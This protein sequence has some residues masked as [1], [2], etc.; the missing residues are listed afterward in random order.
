MNFTS[1]VTG[2]WN[3]PA[4]WGIAPAGGPS[5]PGYT[6]P[7][8]NDTVSITD[9]AAVIIPA[10][11]GVS[12]GSSG[13]I[14]IETNTYL[15]IYGSLDNGGAITADS[16]ITIYPGGSLTNSGSITGYGFIQN[17][18]KMINN[19]GGVITETLLPN[20]GT[21]NFF[22]NEQNATITNDGTIDISAGFANYGSLTNAGTLQVNS[23]GEVTGTGSITNTGTVDLSGLSLQLIETSTLYG[24]FQTVGGT[25]TQGKGSQI[26]LDVGT[27][28]VVESWS[29]SNT[30]FTIPAG[31]SLLIG[32]GSTLTIKGSQTLTNNGTIA[33]QGGFAIPGA[34]IPGSN[35]RPVPRRIPPAS[36]TVDADG[37]LTNNGT[38]NNGEDPIVGFFSGQ[39]TITNDGSIQ[40][41]K[42]ASFNNWGSINNADG[43]VVNAAGGNW[44]N[45]TSV[46][47]GAAGSVKGGQQ[48]GIP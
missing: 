35:P 15:A 1:V 12:M 6:Y 14:N 13:S 25:F 19:S 40:N 28:A 20:G 38:F 7:G 39:P 48:S 2:D 23:T 11:L 43:Q 47:G 8:P 4:T 5:G 27:Q 21:N 30:N 24:D 33:N 44:D 26:V 29:G 22:I 46:L 45:E 34:M 3:I 42:G 9:D 31:A 18:G 37:V 10:G 36:T 32:A 17:F 16:V 41:E